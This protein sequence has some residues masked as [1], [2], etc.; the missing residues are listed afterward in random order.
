MILDVHFSTHVAFVLHWLCISICSMQVY[1][2][3]QMLYRNVSNGFCSFCLLI[4][5]YLNI[6]LS[7][8]FYVR[9]CVDHTGWWHK[10]I[11]YSI[12]KIC[13]PMSRQVDGAFISTMY[14]ACLLFTYGTFPDVSKCIVAMLH[15]T[16]RGRLTLHS[17]CWSMSYD[18][19]RLQFWFVFMICL[20]QSVVIQLKHI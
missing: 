9:K 8:T 11:S 4:R 19:W 20:V 1:S 17:I 5:P 13:G 12:C 7:D 15:L 10:N 14:F 2:F 6:L 3:V 18:H 16:Q